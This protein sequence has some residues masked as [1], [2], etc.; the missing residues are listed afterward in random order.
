MQ[1]GVTKEIKDHEERVGL[2][3]SSVADL[4]DRPSWA[5]AADVP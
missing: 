2:V 1:I 4:E 5:P 3:S